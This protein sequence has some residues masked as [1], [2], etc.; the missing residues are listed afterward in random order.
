[1]KQS[2]PIAHLGV[3]QQCSLQCSATLE[4][5]LATYEHKGDCKSRCPDGYIGDTL[6]R[7]CVTPLGT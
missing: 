6:Q 2:L 7:K 1:M 5:G 4:C 3:I